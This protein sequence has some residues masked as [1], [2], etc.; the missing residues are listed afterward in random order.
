M[1]KAIVVIKPD[2][3]VHESAI[4]SRLK[5]DGFKILQARRMLV[6]FDQGLEYVEVQMRESKRAFKSVEEIETLAE[7]LTSGPCTILVVAAFD[8]VDLLKT[9]IGPQ[10][11][12]Q[13]RQFFPSSL[14]T[15]YATDEVR[16]AIWGSQ[17]RHQVEEEIRIFFPNHL[18]ERLPDHDTNKVLLETALYP[19]LTQG[20][21]ELCKA[22]PENPT[23][24]LGTWLLENNPSQP[25]VQEPWV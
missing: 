1:E 4:L 24:W 11:L 13:A 14:R 2:A 20:L 17:S 19:L 18:M 10:D 5:F 7:H 23:V 8:A 3:K 9:V 25:K 16:D 22:K 6:T 12:F 15:K 21:T